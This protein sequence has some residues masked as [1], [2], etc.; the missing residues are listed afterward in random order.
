MGSQTRFVLSPVA[1]AVAT[2]LVPG[3]AVQ[4]QDSQQARP[5][6]GGLEEI[7]VTARKR[8][9]SAQDIPIAIQALSQ[10]TLAAMGAK[11]MD[12][13]ARFIPS[14]SVI[15]YSNS[16]NIVVFRG[17]I[18]SPGYI[19]AS[20]SSVYLDEISMTITGSQ[21]GV[22]MVDVER[23]EALSGPQGT[24]YGSDAQAGTMRI[25]TNKPDAS[26]FEAIFDGE[27]R[28]GDQSDASYRGSLVFNVPLVEDKLALRVVGYSD[29]D[30]GFI[31]NVFG[32][33]P[34]QSALRG[35]GFY[36][37]GFGTLDNSKAVEERWNDSQVYGGRVNLL[38]DIN[39]K[40]STTL[41]YAHQTSDTGADNYYD[42]YV[43]DLQTVR[44]HDEY[45]EDKYDVFSLTVDGDLGFAQLVSA[46]SYFDRTN[47]YQS[48]VT[49]YAHYWNAQYCRDSNYTLADYPY[50]FANPDTGNIIWWPVYCH[51]PTVDGDSFNASKLKA[52]ANKF[53]QEFRLSAQ[54]DTV[55]WLVGLF[56]ER[57]NDDWQSSFAGPTTGGDGSVNVYQDSLSLAYYEWAAGT[58]FPTA[59]SRWYSE[60]QT[61]WEQK[62]LFG[63]A[64]WHASDQ[65]DVTVG[66]RWYDRSNTNYYFVN[67]P[68]DFSIPAYVT[69]V[70]REGTDK[71]IIP[72]LSVSYTFDDDSTSRMVYGLYT[73]GKRPGGINRQRGEPFFPANYV[74]DLM[75]NYEFGY[76]STFASG[77]GRFNVTAYHMEWKDYQHELT[78]PSSID[79]ARLGLPDTSIAGVCG[80]PW[81]RVVANLGKAHMT[82]VNLELDYAPTE[83]WVLGINAEK[84]QAETDTE[85]DL[86]AD[87]IA[88]VLAGL[89]LP[90]VP[91]FKA[92][93]W[94]EYHFPINFMG[95]NDAFFRT[96][97]SYNGET[98]S[99]LEPIS[100]DESPNPQFVNDAYTIGDIRFG[101]QAEDWE[102]SIFVNN[103][104]D[105][106][107]KLT[108]NDGQFDWG[109]AS[110]ADNRAH[111]LR[112]FTNRPREIGVRY[113]KRWGD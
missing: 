49:A 78:D 102:A 69:P 73:R 30:G 77:Q 53:T 28:G 6:G 36:P 47:K 62:A 15:T 10:D 42:P 22:R 93:A 97:W 50:Y 103:V 19:A 112:I 3:H 31:D 67:G 110:I 98:L 66:G 34:D 85:H 52:Q 99:I 5:S 82:G 33:T 29:S 35:P 9:E 84:M 91:E 79:C 32:H 37:S 13:Y 106:R 87:G 25:V 43:G 111:N 21:P 59:T 88:D 95:N 16:A 104:T 94:A 68:G 101:I 24:L 61:D 11:S 45:T 92:A 63:E 65:L 86:D 58:T 81:Q 48:D 8:T 83:N 76:K 75:D 72:K 107:A 26:K 27:L 80:Q 12:D 89:R 71:E 60:N 40:W 41:G 54:G 23:V 46:T 4:A 39:D 1:A 38:W 108:H 113:M 56:Y 90:L 20:T 57:S 7:V 74:S 100:P 105:E 17:A 109:A 2:S 55:D 14:V 96:Q 44:F 18:T 70:G 64:T 51:A